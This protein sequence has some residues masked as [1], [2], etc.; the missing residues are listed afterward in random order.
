MG[1]VLHED[2]AAWRSVNGVNSLKLCFSL[3]LVLLTD[4]ENDRFETVKFSVTKMSHSIFT[5]A[6]YV[7]FFLTAED[8]HDLNPQSPEN[9]GRNC[10][11]Q[12]GHGQRLGC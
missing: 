11:V 4:K 9:R 1:P 8:L 3:G 7:F 10:F 12:L 5:V 6:M 2:G